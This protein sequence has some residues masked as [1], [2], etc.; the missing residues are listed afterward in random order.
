MSTRKLRQWT[1]VLFLVLLINTAYIAAFNSPTI[2]YMGNV[3]LHL[4]LGV[5]LTVA[6]L[7]LLRQFPAAAGF[8]LAA[9][10]LGV[11]IAV[12]GNTSDHRWALIA[13]IVAAAIGLAAIA[14]FA[15]RQSP[16][17]RKAF[18]FS[19]ALLVVLPL[20]TTLYRKAF[21]HPSARIRNALVVPTS[22]D[23]EGAGPKS[24]FFPSSA[25]TNVG[26]IIPANFFMD[27]ERCGECHKDI[28]QQ[29]KSSVHHFASFNNQFYR[30]SIEYMQSVVGTQPSKWCAGCH[31]HAV[32]FNGRFDRPIKEQIDTPEA[33]AGLA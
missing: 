30:K 33:R 24:P 7:F 12:R 14:P 15:M 17:F 21:P 8:F 16:A 26:G 27:S 19:L 2:F 9:A 3:L 4:V 5:V 28:Y 31:D 10:A 6:L 20:S 13:H 23:G 25:R 32:F 29:W 11:F 22:M 1:A 18:Q